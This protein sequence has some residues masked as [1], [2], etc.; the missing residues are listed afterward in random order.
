MLAFTNQRTTKLLVCLAF[1]AFQIGGVDCARAQRQIERLVRGLVVVGEGEN[2]VLSWRLLAT[3][4]PDTCFNVYRQADD[5]SA[6]KLNKDP[7]TGPTHYRDNSVDLGK[8]TAY[9]VSGQE[10]PA[11]ERITLPGSTPAQPYLSISLEPPAGYHA[12]DCSVGDLDG[13]G[14]YEI[15][16]HMLGRGRRASL[17]KPSA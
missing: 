2:V 17:K 15:V 9:F 11:S 16:V 8:A 3:D 5:A 13:D 4:A 6:V 14:E 10:L 1:T 12:N 7:L